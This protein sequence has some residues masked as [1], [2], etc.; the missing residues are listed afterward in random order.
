[1]IILDRE[2]W[3]F[4]MNNDEIVDMEYGSIVAYMLYKNRILVMR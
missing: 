2:Y 3:M 1:M 4:D